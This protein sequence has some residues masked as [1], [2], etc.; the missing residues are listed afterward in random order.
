MGAKSNEK[1]RRHYGKWGETRNAQQKKFR[2][3]NARSEK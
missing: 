1:K 2:G 3:G